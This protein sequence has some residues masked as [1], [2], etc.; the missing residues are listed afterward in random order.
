MLLVILLLLALVGLYLGAIVS[1]MVWTIQF[2]ILNITEHRFKP[3]RWMLL[4]IPA[5]LFCYNGWRTAC[6][7]GL[8]AWTVLLG[9]GLA[10]IVYLISSR[11]T[12]HEETDPVC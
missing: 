7:S 8:A 9:W 2:I 3:L 6:L 5:G 11:G 1:L 4:T 10:W 12:R